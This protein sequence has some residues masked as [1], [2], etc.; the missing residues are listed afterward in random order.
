MNT[1]LLK[2]KPV[3]TLKVY[4]LT[5]PTNRVVLLGLWS[6]FSNSIVVC[7]HK[8]NRICK[9]HNNLYQITSSTG[10][11]PDKPLDRQKSLSFTQKFLGDFHL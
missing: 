2:L 1:P 3:V 9:K 5:E 7:G 8:W 6:V 10:K 4:E 11:K